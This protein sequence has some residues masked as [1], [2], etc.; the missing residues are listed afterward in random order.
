MKLLNKWI[1]YQKRQWNLRKIQ[2][3][4]HSTRILFDYLGLD[5]DDVNMREAVKVAIKESDEWIER[6][7]VN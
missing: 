4:E 7:M 3:N 2:R 5:Y 1:V 6:H